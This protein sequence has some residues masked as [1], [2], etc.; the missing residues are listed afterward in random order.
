MTITPTSTV[1]PVTISDDGI[2]AVLAGTHLASVR[3]YL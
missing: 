2:R 3:K 1:R